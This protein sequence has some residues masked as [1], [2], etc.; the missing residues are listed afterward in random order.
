MCFSPAITIVF[1][2]SFAAAIDEAGMIV[3]SGPLGCESPFLVGS[4]LKILKE[5]G[6]TDVRN[7]Y[8]RRKDQSQI[9][10]IDVTQKIIPSSDVCT[11]S[12][13][14]YPSKISSHTGIKSHFLASPY[15]TRSLVLSHS[16][17]TN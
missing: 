3:E 15:F 9:A 12:L 2:P 16:T 10:S 8:P 13:N 7:F 14:F 6:M 17:T 4:N 11:K 5:P 1:T